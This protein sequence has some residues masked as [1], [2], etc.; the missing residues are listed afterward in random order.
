[1]K[2]WLFLLAT[3]LSVISA[4]AQ[5]LGFL[6]STDVDTLARGKIWNFVHPDNAGNTRWDLRNNGEAVGTNDAFPAD[7]FGADTGDWTV[8]DKGQ[9]CLK[10][11]TFWAPRCVAVQKDG[12]KLKLFL[13]DDLKNAFAE[14]SVK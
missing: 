9:L 2:S 12:E 8:N 5:N 1:M 10:W 11:K 7:H 14:L 3:A 4:H 6:D 13:S